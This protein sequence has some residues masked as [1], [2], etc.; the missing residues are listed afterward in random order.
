MGK[1]LVN[2]PPLRRPKRRMSIDNLRYNI[3]RISNR[4]SIIKCIHPHQ[5]RHSCRNGCFFIIGARLWNKEGNQMVHLEIISY[6]I[7]YDWRE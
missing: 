1:R 7:I 6:A 2:I 5:L 4:A 3:K